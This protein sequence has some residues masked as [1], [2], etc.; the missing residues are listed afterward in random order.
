MSLDSILRRSEPTAF[1]QF[2]HD[3][4]RF[5][6]AKAY[7]LTAQHTHTNTIPGELPIRVVCISDTH[8]Q[9]A[10]LGTLP[11]GDILIHA[12]DLTH[13]G[14]PEELRDALQWLASQPHPHKLFIVGNHDRA[15]EES[16]AARQHLLDAFPT[17]VYLQQTAVTL[18]VRGRTLR[19]YGSPLTPKHGSWPFQYPRHTP[20]LA[21]W[22]AIPHDTDILI[23]HGPPAHHLDRGS[24]C[25][26]LLSALWTVRPRLHICGH[27]HAARGIESLS[28]SRAQAAYER[29]CSGSGRWW[30]LLVVFFCRTF[31]RA[32]ERTILVNAASLGGFRDEQVRGAIVVDL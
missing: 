16:D 31:L 23:T 27:I 1:E 25:T 22:D 2:T 20:E 17:L 3:P 8:S 21:S 11:D 13:S 7:H 5:L 19:I 32:S 9:H 14:T 6:A 26:A 28:W 4:L 15:L 29:I 30:D 24:G 18:S 12:G 10:Q